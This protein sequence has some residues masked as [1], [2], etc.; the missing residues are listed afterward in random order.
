MFRLAQVSDPHFRCFRLARLRDL[1]GKRALGGLN[2]LVQ[3]RR[4]H[5]MALLQALLEDLRGRDF[6]HLALTGDLCNI[7]LESE[8]SAALRWIAATKLPLDR[9]T[10]IPGNHD[11]YVPAVVKDGV[12][13][14]MF[15]AYQ[16]ADLRVGEAVYPFVRFRGEL[17]LLCVSTAVP[18]GDLGAWGRVGESQLARLESLL[19]AP[20]VKARRRV[21]LIHHPP[22][23]NR[24]GEDLNL[25]DREALQALLLRTGADLVMHGHDHRDFFKDL[26]GPGGSR[27]PVVGVGSASYVSGPDR[28]SRYNIFEFEG[29]AIGVVTYAH[30]EASGRF[31]E[32]RRKQLT[33]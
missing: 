13:E 30:D 27:I 28:R 29:M 18:T 16:T 5:S 25:R 19:G 10:V 8:W 21:I 3:R 33:G 2:L 22:L 31:V 1:L 17:A 26:P 24:P 15:A 20:E 11:A 4:K 9:V 6:D 14:R 12:F 23:V 7:S 32:Y